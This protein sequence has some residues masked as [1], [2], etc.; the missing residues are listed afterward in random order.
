MLRKLS[1][2]CLFDPTQGLNDVVQD[3][4]IRDGWLVENPGPG[5]QVDEEIDVS[6]QIVMAGAVDIHT[7]VAGGNVNNARR[8][9]PQMQM[10]SSQHAKRVAGLP[11]PARGWSATGT[12]HRYACMGYTTVVEPAVLPCNALSAQLEMADIPILDTAGLAI[13][14]NDELLLGMLQARA[15]QSAINDYVAWTLDATRC[16][17]IKVINAGGVNAFKSNAASFG[18]D[19]IVPMYG[20]SS[21]EILQ[22]LQRAV[23]QLGVNHPLHVHC[24]NLGVAGRSAETAV[25]TMEAAEGMPMHL[26]HVQFYGYGE[27]GA[28]AFSSASACLIDAWKRHPNVTMDVGQVLFGPTVTISSDVIAQFNN[29]AAANP[30]RAVF[31]MAECEG[32]GGVVPYVYR[33]QSFVN[34][35]QWAIGLELFLLADDPSRL[36]FTTD[37]PNGAPFTRYPELFRLLM[38]ADY[39]AEVMATMNQ[40]AIAMTLLPHLK[41][42]YSLYEIAIMTRSAAAGLMGLHDRGSLAPGHLADV[43]VYAPQDDYAAMFRNVKALFKSGVQVVKDGEVIA[44]PPGRSLHALPDYDR[45]AA[46]H[47]VADYYRQVMTISPQNLG[48]ANHFDGSEESAARFVEVATADA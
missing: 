41:R 21:R 7:H 23:V 18:L 12:G 36:F 45:S 5:T 25:A 43:A 15:P 34:T 17:G 37:H 40:D 29:R 1:G 13:L 46:D 31:S 48:V 28:N 11:N 44:S 42:E 38:D 4:F 8:L 20:I 19:D 24:N 30:K 9:M 47:R 10:K 14:G 39:R 22:A 26:A 35:L 33:E 27:E 6:G 3:L 32:G 16:L 2:G